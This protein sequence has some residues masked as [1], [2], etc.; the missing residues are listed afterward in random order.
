MMDELLRDGPGRVRLPEGYFEAADPLH[1]DGS[2]I[3]PVLDRFVGHRDPQYGR[4]WYDSKE[5]SDEFFDARLAAF[6]QGGN[7]R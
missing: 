2:P 7:K 3:E 5:T 1:E 4:H 6:T